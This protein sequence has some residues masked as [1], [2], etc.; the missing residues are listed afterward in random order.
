M[1]TDKHTTHIAI[2]MATYNGERFL[3]EQIDSLL[4]QTCPDWHLYVHD[5]GSTDGTRA[6][7]NSYVSRYPDK[8]TLLDYPSQGGPCKNFL[9]MLER[10]DAPYYMFCDQ[11]DVWLP[12]KVALSMDE[13]KRQE[14][15]APA[16]SVVIHTDLT[17]ADEH[18]QPVY[19]SM[20][21]YSGI[22]PQYIKTF[23]DAAGHTTI[24]TGSTMLFNQAA[25]EACCTHRADKA[26]MHDSWLC[27]C[28]LRHGG[29]VRGIS[30]QSV[31]YRQH[32]DNCLGSGATAAT[33]VDIKYRI[34]HFR[35]MFR[36]NKRY[37]DM[38]SS[39]GYDSVVNYLLSKIRYKIRIRRGHY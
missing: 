23:T 6:V 33:A 11:D 16:K 9:S 34:Q 4:S 17:I 15:K 29:I 30:Y 2:L 38:L 3:C 32:G 12:E 31:L 37:Y 39:L 25:K 14:A 24:A 19:G 36:S 28:T 13:M 7:V 1:T 10:V 21:Q 27:L 18:L 35:R 22:Y 26:L 8:V 20:W 5:D